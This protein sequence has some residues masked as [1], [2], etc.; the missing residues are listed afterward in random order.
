MTHKTKHRVRRTP[1]KTGGGRRC[2][3]RVI[4]SHF[5]FLKAITSVYLESN[6]FIIQLFIIIWVS[7]SLFKLCLKGSLMMYLLLVLKI[8]LK[9]SIKKSSIL[10]SKFDTRRWVA[11]RI[12]HHLPQT[13]CR[14]YHLAARGGKL[15][16]PVS[17][18]FYF[19]SYNSKN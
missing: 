15:A 7:G 6:I 11:Y 12:S 14:K 1:P 4:S 18:N 3:G 13:P 19:F 16:S 2:S 17:Y 9:I 10:R 5:P 8:V